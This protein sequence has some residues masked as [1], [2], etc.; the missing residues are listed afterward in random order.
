VFGG[1][2]A[3]LADDPRIPGRKA[4]TPK[5]MAQWMDDCD[6][7]LTVLSWQLVRSQHVRGTAETRASIARELARKEGGARDKVVTVVHGMNPYNT[8]H[9]K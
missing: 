4:R 6:Q 1:A 7:G 5:T 9:L 8:L 3:A 2:L